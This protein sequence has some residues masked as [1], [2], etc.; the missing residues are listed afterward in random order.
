[1]NALLNTVQEPTPKN[2]EQEPLVGPSKRLKDS[3]LELAEFESQL[4][5]FQAVANIVAEGSMIE[6]GF[7]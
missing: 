3:Y 1:M 4:L 2:M 5:R 6:S 7:D